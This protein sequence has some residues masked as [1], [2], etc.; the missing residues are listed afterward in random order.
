[1]SRGLGKVKDR[2]LS[3]LHLQ[4]DHLYQLL[5]HGVVDLPIAGESPGAFRMPRQYT[6]EVR[7]LYLFIE[8][9]DEGAAGEVAAG[10][11]VEGDG[12]LLAGDGIDDDDG[13]C[14]AGLRED[15]LDGVV[16]SLF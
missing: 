10:G 11:S 9:A 6:D 15:F 2:V 14:E 16:V 3:I 8:V 7:I 1:M 12:F 5:F 13:T 4:I